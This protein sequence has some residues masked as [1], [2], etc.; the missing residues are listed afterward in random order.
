MR[1]TSIEEGLRGAWWAQGFR[2]QGFPVHVE[3]PGLDQPAGKAW[4]GGEIPDDISLVPSFVNDVFIWEENCHLEV[5]DPFSP[6]YS[7]GISVGVSKMRKGTHFRGVNSHMSDLK[8]LEWQRRCGML[9]G[10]GESSDLWGS[11]RQP[12][13]CRFPSKLKPGRAHHS[14][15][16]GECGRQRDQ[17]GRQRPSC[18]GLPD[19]HFIQVIETPRH[20][21][22]LDARES[23]WP[24]TRARG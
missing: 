1:E 20:R 6:T 8:Q 2:P 7:A 9:R 11:S 12:G 15:E 17:R 18:L 21:L 13:S 24:C 16:R 10:S 19:C 14:R 23:H 3:Y 5:S 4:R 22:C